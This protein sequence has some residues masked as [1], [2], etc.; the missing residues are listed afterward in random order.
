MF[1]A[2]WI[3]MPQL[4]TQSYEQFSIKHYDEV[5]LSL[6]EASRTA[7]EMRKKTPGKFYRIVPTGSGS[8]GFHV[9][10]VEPELAYSELLARITATF[11]RLLSR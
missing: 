10:T 5:P 4:D 1:S 7:A 2:D 3:F 6:S 9:E 11:A 8:D